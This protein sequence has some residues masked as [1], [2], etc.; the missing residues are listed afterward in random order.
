MAALEQGYKHLAKMA[1]ISQEDADQKAQ[2]HRPMVKALLV[3]RWKQGIP[4]IQTHHSPAMPE[5]Y[6]HIH[7]ELVREGMPPL[8]A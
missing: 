3:S 5:L 2:E 1:G 4:V 7:G 8:S 6:S